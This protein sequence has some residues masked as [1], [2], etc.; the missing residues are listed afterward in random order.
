MDRIELI[1]E[2]PTPVGQHLGYGRSIRNR[3]HQ[4]EIR[5]PIAPAER[6]RPNDGPGDHARVGGGHL[7]HAV[8]YAV[9]L[10]DAEHLS[11]RARERR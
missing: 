6:K 1:N 4:V 11:D 10:L 2:A 8:T 9:A 7:Q 3:E 5:P